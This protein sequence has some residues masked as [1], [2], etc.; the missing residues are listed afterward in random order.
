MLF[1]II[2]VLVNVITIEGHAIGFLPIR[3]IIIVHLIIATAGLAATKFIL[4]EV[5]FAVE[6]ILAVALVAVDV[7]IGL[8]I[9]T[10]ER[11][12]F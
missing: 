10:N 4:A 3:F 2:A 8:A 7:N 11:T 6:F 12:S 9:A 5:L 1:D